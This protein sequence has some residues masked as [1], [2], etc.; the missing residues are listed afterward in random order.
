MTEPFLQDKIAVVTGGAS[1]IGLATAE[2]LAEAGATV[3]ISDVQAEAGQAAAQ[4]VN[5]HFI[6]SD[7]SQRSACKA[8]IE[9]TLSQLGAVHILVN[10]AGIQHIDPIDEFPEDTWDKMLALMLTAPFLLTRYVWPTMKAQQWGRVINIGSLLSVRGV[11]YKAAYVSVKHGILGL[12]RTTALE[13]GPFG[14]SAHCICPAWVDTPLMR[15]QIADQARTRNLSEDEVIEK[16]M[17]EPAAIKRLIQPRE[18][19]G[20][21]TFLCSDDAAAMSGS[22]VMIDVGQAAH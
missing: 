8:L 2:R 3:V 4:Q 13:G 6:Q 19:G 11:A 5:G 22:P 17:L 15:N 20:L 21:I 14:I 9:Q 16:F 7:L 10:N 18:I 1:G 12:T